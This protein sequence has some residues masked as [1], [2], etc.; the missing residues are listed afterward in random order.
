MVA[1]KKIEFVEVAPHLS[2]EKRIERAVVNDLLAAI[3]DKDRRLI[4]AALVTEQA[5]DLARRPC[6]QASSGPCHEVARSPRRF[7]GSTRTFRT[8]QPL[9]G[10]R[11]AHLPKDPGRSGTFLRGSNE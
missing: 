1:R 3:I 9:P 6:P 11:R 4:E 2:L 8:R 5:S 7:A 10:S